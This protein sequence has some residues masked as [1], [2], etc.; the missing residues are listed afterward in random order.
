ME[1]GSIATFLRC[2]RDEGRAMPYLPAALRHIRAKSQAD[3]NL[4]RLRQ[5]GLPDGILTVEHMMSKGALSSS[6][7]MVAMCFLLCGRPE[8][9]APLRFN[10][11]AHRHAIMHP[12]HT[13]RLSSYAYL[14]THESD[15]AIQEVALPAEVAGDGGGSKQG[16][17]PLR[18][19][20]PGRATSM[21][22]QAA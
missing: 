18:I 8:L 19:I 17:P 9:S 20:P 22:H 3:E 11:K 16:G 14:A 4:A 2:M 15:T 5:L 21:S 1:L 10:P 7:C 6:A 13:A 12:Y